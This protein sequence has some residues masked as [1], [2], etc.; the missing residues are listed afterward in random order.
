MYQYRLLGRVSQCVFPSLMKAKT[1]ETNWLTRS[2]VTYPLLFLHRNG[3]DYGGVLAGALAGACP[4]SSST[5]V[6][7][8]G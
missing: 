6:A 7:A 8:V 3:F 4:T 1:N 5:T 2:T